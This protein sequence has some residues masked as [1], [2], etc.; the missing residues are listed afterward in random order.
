VDL[1]TLRLSLVGSPCNSILLER[2]ILGMLKDGDYDEG[3]AVALA[4][5][6]LRLA[7]DLARSVGVPMEV[8]ATVENVYRRARAR[9]G[10]KA[11]EMIPAKMYEDDTNTPLRFK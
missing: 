10:D 11:G 2:D 6:D 8:G 5:K 7:G 1:E 9:Y 4:C 3:F